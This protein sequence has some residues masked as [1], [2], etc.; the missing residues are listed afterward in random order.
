MPDF[1]NGS[2][3]EA[4]PTRKKASG[5]MASIIAQGEENVARLEESFSGPITELATD[6]LRLNPDNPRRRIS[7]A[8][9]EEMI[10]GIRQVGGEILQPLLVRPVPQDEHG[11]RYEVVCG[12]RRLTAARRL[13]MPKV[14]V[15][16]REMD[17]E[18]AARFALWENLAREDL[19]AMDLAESINGLRLIEKLSWEEIGDRFGFSRQWGWKQ[20]KL[21][22][23]PEV[24]K[25]MVR[26]GDL[27]PSKAMLLSQAAKVDE[28]IIAL[29]GKV[30][31]RNLSHRALG[32]EI[33]TLRKHV[34]TSPDITTR[35]GSSEISRKHVLTWSPPHGE[36]R[37]GMTRLIRATEEIVDALNKGTF[38]G[39]YA[40]S[41]R[42]ILER[43]L[44]IADT[45]EPDGSPPTRKDQQDLKI[46][47]APT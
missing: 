15:R 31:T 32:T 9:V 4:K 11:C 40:Q 20:Q 2:T 27:S 14:P 6:Y 25:E 3:R 42:P 19:D 22:S 24:V 5:A 1:A 21:V 28:E 44:D 36:S 10:N 16:I 8:S 46:P 34:L 29:A 38:S 13:G 12:N 43:I 30:V 35:A 37:R 23:L 7:A 45:G 26:E 18:Q 17:A 41:M 47:A 39:E 33:A